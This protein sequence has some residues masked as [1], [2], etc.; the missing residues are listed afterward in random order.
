VGTSIN[1]Y[2]KNNV[3]KY[4]LK[5]WE[6]IKLFVKLINR[7]IIQIILVNKVIKLINFL[8]LEINTL[9]KPKKVTRSKMTIYLWISLIKEIIEMLSIINQGKLVSLT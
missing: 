4:N 7:C 9:L 2:K 1:I 5:E 6:K 3:G 8:N